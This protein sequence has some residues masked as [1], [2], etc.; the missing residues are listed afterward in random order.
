MWSFILEKKKKKT[1]ISIAY[2]PA[3]DT[4][5]MWG[6]SFSYLAIRAEVQVIGLS[7]N[8]RDDD[9]LKY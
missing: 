6:S 8:C 4:V 9:E 2:K 5:K 7:C 3:D 1:E